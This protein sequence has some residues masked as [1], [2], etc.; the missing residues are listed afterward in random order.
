MA[1][2]GGK[3]EARID[4]SIGGTWT[5]TLTDAGGTYGAST[6]TA[7]KYYLS[8]V[9]DQALSLMAEMAAQLNLASASSDYTVTLSSSTG[10]ITI[11]K[12][13]GTFSLTW[14]A[15]TGLR[16]A[17]GWTG[18]ISTG[19]SAT[20][21]TQSPAL[22]IPRGPWASDFDEQS[23]GYIVSDDSTVVAPSGQVATLGYNTRVQRQIR[24]LM[25]FARY[26]L[27]GNESTTNESLETFWRGAIYAEQV[28]A[29]RG[30]PLRWYPSY[31]DDATYH[32]YWLRNVET[33]QPQPSIA[34][35]TG[36]YDM[37]FELLK[38]VD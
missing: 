1:N 34:D 2:N 16:G 29:E 24:Y 26:I 17:L 22:W 27:T 3:F 14:G 8:T 37:Q 7:G 38:Y 35:F 25:L 30:S 28:W 21:T 32:T 19:T 11:A 6:I 4:T 9:G 23:S 18:N 33:F 12:G 20:A 10:L 5:F 13:S 31:S 36:L 15:A